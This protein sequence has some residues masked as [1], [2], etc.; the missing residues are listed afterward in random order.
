[1]DSEKLCSSLQYIERNGNTFNIDEKMRLGLACKE[2]KTDMGF[3]K[4]W[5]VSKITGIVK[6]YFVV[7]GMKGKEAPKRFWCSSSTWVFSQMPKGLE[8]KCDLAKLKSINTFFTGE[9]D[10]V[11]I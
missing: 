6:D 9:F 11:L 8:N 3:D 1:M 10:S 7:V 2:L 4:I 5:V